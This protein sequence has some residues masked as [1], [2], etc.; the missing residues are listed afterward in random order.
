[1]PL[2]EFVRMSHVTGIPKLDVTQTQALN[3]RNKVVDDELRVVRL[4][5]GADIPVF[6]VSFDCM[7]FPTLFGRICRQ[8][9][10]VPS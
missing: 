10:K 5:S 8:V 3:T 7:Y 9:T 4:G 6:F 2:A 1:M